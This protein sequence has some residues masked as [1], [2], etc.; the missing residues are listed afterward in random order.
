MEVE[1]LYFDG[2]PS[3]LEAEYRR[4]PATW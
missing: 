3:Y 1:I 2:C 4:R